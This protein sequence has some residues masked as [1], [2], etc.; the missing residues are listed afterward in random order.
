MKRSIFTLIEL[1]IVVAIIAILAGMLL[2]ALNKAREKTATISC[3][4]NLKQV[5]TAMGMYHSDFNDY[6][7]KGILSKTSQ[8]YY[9]FW[10]WAFC[11][12]KYV[13]PSTFYC[14]PLPNTQ[15]E[16]FMNDYRKNK[17]SNQHGWQYGAFGLNSSEMGGR[18]YG[19]NGHWLK[20]GSVRRNDYFL[21]AVESS[22]V[23]RVRNKKEGTCARPIHENQTL[24]N[25][26]RGDGHVVSIRGVGTVEDIKTQ[27]YSA[28][29]ILRA[30]NYDDN[31]WTRTGKKRAN[32]DY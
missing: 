22:F 5:G 30:H 2:P 20:T 12:F 23:A 28:N 4:S 27:W 3:I 6:Y 24:A 25:S 26:L 9:Y 19:F 1:L 15:T 17:V 32:E 13:R 7:P 16:P 18:E 10:T 31:P 21:V 8:D 11:D 29:G 14:R